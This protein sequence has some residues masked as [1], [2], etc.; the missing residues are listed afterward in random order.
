MAD[1]QFWQDIAGSVRGFGKDVNQAA[2][3][4][5]QALG[6]YDEMVRLKADRK[7][8]ER[9]GEL[10]Y[11]MMQE[12]Q[13]RR[14]QEDAHKEQQRLQEEADRGKKEESRREYLKAYREAWA[15]GQRDPMFF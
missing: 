8:K 9:M 12:D 13:Q 11:E 2:Q 7:R 3:Q 14:L 10:E 15:Q 1:A 6:A 4:G 5:A